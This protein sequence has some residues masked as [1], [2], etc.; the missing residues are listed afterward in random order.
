MATI[1]KKLQP[2]LCREENRMT[3][4]SSAKTGKPK[5]SQ[6]QS[7]KCSTCCCGMLSDK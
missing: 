1:R 6:R 3:K 2:A 5:P 4:K 7:Y